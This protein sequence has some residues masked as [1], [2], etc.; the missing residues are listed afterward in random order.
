MLGDTVSRVFM[1]LGPEAHFETAPAVAG[2][3][4]H[5]VKNA[6]KNTV[7]S[8][9]CLIPILFQVENPLLQ[10]GSLVLVRSFFKKSRDAGG[11]DSARSSAEFD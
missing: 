4:W 7:T 10:L 9:L 5:T 8:F 6:V 3:L 2:S 11:R 1:V